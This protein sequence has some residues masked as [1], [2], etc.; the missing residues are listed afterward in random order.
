L[1]STVTPQDEEAVVLEDVGIDHRWRHR[2]LGGCF[3]LDRKADTY[4]QGNGYGDGNSYNGADYVSANL[5]AEGNVSAYRD[6]YC[7]SDTEANCGANRCA[8]SGADS[9]SHSLPERVRCPNQ[10]TERNDRGRLAGR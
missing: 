4:S 6:A 3:R 5:D 10:G 1:A 8:N 2:G 7:G 9:N